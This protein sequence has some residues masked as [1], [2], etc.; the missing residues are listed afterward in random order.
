MNKRKTLA[1]QANRFLSDL[2]ED[3]LSA[4]QPETTFDPFSP[5]YGDT[6]KQ[7]KSSVDSSDD[8]PM[9][10]DVDKKDTSKGEEEKANFGFVKKTYTEISEL[11][12][13][14]V[15]KTKN[16]DE[17]F[18]ELVTD[19]D[20]ASEE[21]LNSMEGVSKQLY[22]DV[23]KFQSILKSVLEIINTIDDNE[24]EE[25]TSEI[26]TTEKPEEEIEGEEESEAEE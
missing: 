19:I 26:K 5:N 4:P 24:E 13:D 16:L 20:S 18:D 23:E 10:T 25:E 6:T 11:F 7:T 17:K 12:K 21:K 9:G 1:E 3:F 22:E 15:N 14:I 8:K 2:T